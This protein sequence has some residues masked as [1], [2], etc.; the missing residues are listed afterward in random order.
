MPTNARRRARPPGRDGTRQV[1]ELQATIV[2]LREELERARIG[3]ETRIQTA[4]TAA[5]DEITM[6]KGAVQVLRDELDRARVATQE[7]ADAVD[8]E[9]RRQL[10]EAQSTVVALR[11][12]LEPR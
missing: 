10:A 5:H 1:R 11:S 9:W 8:H 6:L 7:Q 2:A 3:E 12:K 4:A